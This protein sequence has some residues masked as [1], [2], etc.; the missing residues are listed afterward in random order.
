MLYKCM[1]C[2]K[3]WD[4]TELHDSPGAQPPKRCPTGEWGG[5]GGLA[6]ADASIEGEPTAPDEVWTLS[7]AVTALRVEDA[8]SKREERTDLDSVWATIYGVR[9][10]LDA[11]LAAP[12]VIV[13]EIEGGVAEE[14]LVSLT[15]N[16]ANVRAILIDWDNIRDGDEKPELPDGLAYSGRGIQHDEGKFGYVRWKA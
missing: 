3:V 14:P 12:L 7:E 15:G 11:H 2:G 13:T 9:E 1:E 16:P 6:E 4:A 10:A 5:C 8:Y